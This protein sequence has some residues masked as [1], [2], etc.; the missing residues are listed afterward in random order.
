MVGSGGRYEFMV[1]VW[2]GVRVRAE[3]RVGVCGVGWGGGAW[4]RV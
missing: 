1:E 3:V 2:I 4:V